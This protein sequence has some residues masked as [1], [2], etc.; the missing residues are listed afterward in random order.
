MKK[1]KIFIFPVICVI[2][3]VGT[4]IFLFLLT[5]K[6]EEKKYNINGIEET[7]SSNI[8][9]ESTEKNEVENNDLSNNTE[10]NLL[11]NKTD[12]PTV[13]EQNQEIEATDKIEQAINLVKKQ[14]GEDSTVTFRCDHVTSNGE[15]VIAV[16]SK[17]SA[18]VKNYFKVNLE[19]KTVEVDY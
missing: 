5:K 2:I 18:S 17:N 6:V 10:I 19:E 14:W 9:N 3:V 15:Y 4:L 13:Y 7:S 11:E 1:Y 12:E 16:I 8:E